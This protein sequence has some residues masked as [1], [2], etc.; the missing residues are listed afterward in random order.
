MSLDNSMRPKM[1]SNVSE[2]AEAL[3]EEGL[4]IKELEKDEVIDEIL[5]YYGCP[6]K[7][8]GT[9]CR[10]L[11]VPFEEND[12]ERIGRANP[13]NKE[14]L[15]KL[16]Q[17]DETFAYLDNIADTDRA[18]PE[19]PCPFLSNRTSLCTIHKVRPGSCRLYPFLTKLNDDPEEPTKYELALCLMGFDIFIEYFSWSLIAF[20]D[21]LPPEEINE[22]LNF[23][24]IHLITDKTKIENIKSAIFPNFGI[25]RAFLFYL[26]TEDAVSRVQNREQLKSNMWKE[27]LKICQEKEGN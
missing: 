19:K 11:E 1:I 27:L 8:N 6:K 10:V 18:F 26:N 17:I 21:A 9:C 2:S 20:K 25:L 4:R 14:I 3:Q 5:S 16:V 22:I 7:C 23:L 24:P 15:E 13:R 12:I